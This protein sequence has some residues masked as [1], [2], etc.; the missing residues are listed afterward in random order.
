MG[1][2]K[3]GGGFRRGREIGDRKNQDSKSNCRSEIPRTKTCQVKIS[4]VSRNGLNR[5]MK[6]S[7]GI[8]LACEERSRKSGLCAALCGKV[9]LTK[10]QYGGIR[11]P[12]HSQDGAS[13]ERW[14]T[15][16]SV[17]LYSPKLAR[18]QGGYAGRGLLASPF[19]T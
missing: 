12:P 2:K 9:D 16:C 18:A 15:R 17:V 5:N 1:G 4:D 13:G 7:H 11:K 14:S 10:G 3:E 19:V 8:G 6:S